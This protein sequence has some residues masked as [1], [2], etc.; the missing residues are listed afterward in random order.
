MMTKLIAQDDNQNKQFQCRIYQN[1][2]RGIS[3]IK[4]MFRE[5]IKI[6]ISQIVEIGE[7]HSVGGYN[8]DRMT[9][10]DQCIIRTIEVILEEEISEGIFD[11]IRITDVKI[12]EVDIEENK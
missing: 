12:I 4:T 2:R 9:E 6:D 11:Q 7:Y 5:I 1:K 10:T 8:L 3:T